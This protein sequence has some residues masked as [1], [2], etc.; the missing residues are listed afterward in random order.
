MR[1]EGNP[2]EVPRRLTDKKVALN[3][4]RKEEVHPGHATRLTPRRGKRTPGQLGLRVVRTKGLQSVSIGRLLASRILT[5]KSFHASFKPDRSRSSKPPPE[6]KVKSA[7]VAKGSSTGSTKAAESSKPRSQTPARSPKKKNE[8]SQKPPGFKSKDRKLS[9]KELVRDQAHHWIAA[10]ANRLDPKGYVEETRSLRFFGH[11]QVL[12]GLE[13]VAIIDWARK[14][15]ELGMRHPLPLL[16]E[17]LFSSFVAS[18][19]TANHPLNRDESIY[20][21][22]DD[23]R[24]RF[25]RGWVLT[26]VVLQF[27]TDEQSILDGVINGGR[28]RPT[29]ALAHYVMTQLNPVVP[30]DLQITWDQVVART[31]W[32]GRRLEATEAECRTI[33]R[34]PIPVPGEASDLEIAME[35][36]YKRRVAA[37][38]DAPGP[39]GVPAG[40]KTRPPMGRGAVL[41]AHLDKNKYEGWSRLPGKTPGPD[42]AQ[43]YAPPRRQTAEESTVQ[44]TPA[45]ERVESTVANPNCSPLS[46]EL[47]P[48]AEVTQLLDYDDVADQDQDPELASAVASILPPEDVEMQEEGVAPGCGFNPE[49]MQHGFDQDFA[50]SRETGPGSTSPVTAR[51]DEILNDP[52]GKAPGEGRP[53]AKKSGQ[54]PSRQN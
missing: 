35:E 32:V 34:Q 22:T 15:L 19:Q 54:D 42:V 29:S 14:Y 1:E 28:I 37:A 2:T 16:P 52:T 47:D 11:Q 46:L 17:Y 53:G 4:D 10:Q 8:K 49:L 38:G 26:A 21:D 20:S 30:E 41:K 3:Q 6:P 9:E 43:P 23:L 51:D 12:Y 44:D 25:Q 48:E 7:V 31:P 13:L 5:P 33:L 40:D 50:R 24:E 27:W 36:S 18:R 45:E 39:K